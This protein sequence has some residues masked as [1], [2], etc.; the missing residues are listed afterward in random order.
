MRLRPFMV[1]ATASPTMV[2]IKTDTA[3]EPGD[4]PL[5]WSARWSL[6]TRILAV[7]ILAVA[8]LASG[9]FYLDTYRTR[10]VDTRIAVM[11]DKLSMFDVALEAARPDQRQR[12]IGEFTRVTESRLRFYDTSGRKI[13]D[14]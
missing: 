6:T 8:L 12:L 7:N 13:D 9:F 4:A 5:V 3:A 14:S 10:L 11:V 2:R 1:R